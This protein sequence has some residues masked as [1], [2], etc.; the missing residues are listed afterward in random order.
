MNVKLKTIRSVDITGMGS[1]YIYCATNFK[2]GNRVLRNNVADQIRIILF[3]YLVTPAFDCHLVTK[4]A[5]V[6]PYVRFRYIL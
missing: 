5:E 4:L 2:I 3:F 6:S 1:A